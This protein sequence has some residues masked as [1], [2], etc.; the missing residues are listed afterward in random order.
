M[1]VSIR[2]MCEDDRRPVMDI[3]NHYIENSFAAYPEHPLPYQAFDVFVQASRGYPSATLRN[4]DGHI[5][6]FGLLR[7]HRPIPTF[8]QAAEITYFIHPEYTGKGLGK[9]LLE[10]FEHA[11]RE[12]GI[13][14]I[15]A[16]ISSL[17]PGSIAF[18]ETNGFR[19]CGRF[20]NVGRKNDRVFDT[21]WMQKFL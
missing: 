7:G 18:H 6:G 1:D 15:L 9:R 17:N 4:T 8:A 19:E 3:F 16:H 14:T 2:P 12:Q 11:A 20:R 10:H 21:V 5:I 13:T